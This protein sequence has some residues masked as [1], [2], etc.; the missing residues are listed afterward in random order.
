VRKVIKQTVVGGFGLLSMAMLSSCTTITPQ[1]QLMMD[2]SHCT[3]IGFPD[4]SV[5]LAECVQRMELDRH[6]DRR[7]SQES[8]DRWMYDRPYG[9]PWRPYRH[10]P[11]Y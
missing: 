11:W 3:A 9:P 7:A 8:M 6:A 5:P 2:R 4:Q 10:Y 1:E